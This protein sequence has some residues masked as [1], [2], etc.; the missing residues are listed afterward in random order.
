VAFLPGL[1]GTLFTEFAYTVAGAT[2]I[3]GIVV[4]TLSPMMCSKLLR[5]GQRQTR[6]GHW[7]ER[8]FG[9]TAWVYGALLRYALDA[10]WVVLAFG[11]AILVARYVLYIS[12]DS[13]LAPQEDQGFLV[14]LASANPNVSL[15]QLERW[16]SELDQVIQD[17]EATRFSFIV[18]GFGGSSQAFGGMALRPWQ[19]RD[20][21]TMEISPEVQQRVYGIAGLQTA[22]FAPP[23]LPGAGGGPPVELVIGST[24]EPLVVFE[25]TQALLAGARQSGQFSYI[26]TDLKFDHADRHRHRSCQ[27]GRPRYRH[28]HSRAEPVDAAVHGLRE[29]LQRRRPELS[30]NPTGRPPVSSH[31]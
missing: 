11:A 19:E 30:G 27:S 21:T 14:L 23:T 29:F 5:R 7:V 26:D 15:D 9:V 3:S 25:A 24:A 28:G 2:L 8:G 20:K 4:L 13:E 12:A 16:T 18:N 22:V 1:T 10:R 17:I 31:P 6:L